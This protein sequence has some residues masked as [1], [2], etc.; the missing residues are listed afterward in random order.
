MGLMCVCACACVRAYVRVS[1]AGE[2]NASFMMHGMI[3]YLLGPSQYATV[4]RK[5]FV[6]YV[7]PML[8]PDGVIL[9]NYR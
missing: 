5:N 4:L 3:E 2:S 8:N 9:G 7:V 1:H 6:I